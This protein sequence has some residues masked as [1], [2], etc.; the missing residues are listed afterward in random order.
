MKCAV[1]TDVDATGFCRNCGKA[2]CAQCAREIRGALYCEECVARLMASP[3]PPSAGYAYPSPASP[4]APNPGAAL[5]LGFIPGVGAV[6]NG[7]YIK[8]LIH[9]L[10]FGGI[11]AMLN[12]DSISGG[13][14]AML[15][16]FLGIFCV[17]MP[18]DA[19]LTAKAKLAG[20]TP[21]GFFQTAPVSDESGG[22]NGVQ[23]IPTGAIVLM[24]I[25]II[26][27][28]GNFGYLD[29]V[30]VYRFWPLA[31]VAVGAWM[32]WKRAR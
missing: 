16:V 22:A 7:E 9:V 14:Q 8:G 1:H 23:R 28:L 31:L 3:A 2:L 32:I 5:G 20:Q 26:F 17:Y 25:G 29:S 6:Y 11:I 15:G 18:I 27:L 13:M 24:I 10:I 12:N 19:Y 30:Y 4:G 21:P